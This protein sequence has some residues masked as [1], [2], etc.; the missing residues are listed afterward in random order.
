MHTVDV[1]RRHVVLGRG[2]QPVEV[3]ACE[4]GK[5]ARRECGQRLVHW[6]IFGGVVDMLQNWL[7]RGMA[8]WEEK[9]RRSTVA[10]TSWLAGC[11][12]LLLLLMLRSWTLPVAASSRL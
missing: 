5:V 8:E 3:V 4:A 10:C 2:R 11:C 6:C 12:C 1:I 7:T 9:D